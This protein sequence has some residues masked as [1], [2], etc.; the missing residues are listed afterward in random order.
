MSKFR[1]TCLAFIVSLTLLNYP[2]QAQRIIFSENFNGYPQINF[3]YPW[4]T[5]GS[6]NSVPW[7]SDVAY[8]IY[9]LG[10][11]DFENRTKMAGTASRGT[12]EHT[13]LVTPPINLGAVQH[14]WLSYDSYFLKAQNGGKTESATVEIRLNNDSTW[15]ILKD[16]PVSAGRHM[17]RSYVDLSSFIGTA[18]VWLGFRYS[19][20]LS[21]MAG[22]LVDNIKVFEPSEHDIALIHSY[23]EDTML[24]Y[25]A[26]PASIP[27]SGAVM[28][29][30]TMP[31]TSFTVAYQEG[32]GPVQTHTISG[33]N[34]APF[35]TLRFVH[36][37]PYSLATV[38]RHKL[39]MWVSTPQDTTSGNDTLAVLLH[40]AKF[41]PVKKIAI[42]EGTGTWNIY[43]PRGHVYLHKLDSGGHP[44]TRISV[45]SNDVMGQKAYAD[46]LYAMDQ[47]FV[48][49]FIFDRRGPVPYADFFERYETQKQ[50]FGFADIHFTGPS[51]A[52][53]LA[54]EAII[55]PAVNL[56]GSYRLALVV[57]EDGVKGTGDD[58]A[59]KNA[60]VNGHLGPMG[61]F[62]SKPDPV[63]ASDMV[64]DYVARS[65]NPDVLGQAGCLPMQMVAGTSYKCNLHATYAS[66]WNY[67]KL[68]AIVLLIR[69]SDSFRSFSKTVLFRSLGMES[70]TAGSGLMQIHPNPA[71]SSASIAFE[72]PSRLIT[73]MAVTDITGRVVLQS[74]GRW[75]DAGAQK[76]DI[77]VS[78]LPAG[79][80]FITLHAGDR[81]ETRKLSVVH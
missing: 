20:S 61:G 40:G 27:M 71:A 80:Y 39:K 57:T 70:F 44:P 19:D 30:G 50:Y 64:Y 41:I 75:T 11:L 78:R 31:I 60:Y 37:I 4:I 59:Q 55:I 38:D 62:E 14:A 65:I 6:A 16:A 13:L 22:W 74:P 56:S 32:L 15:T 25:F 52:G 81:Q 7:I 47:T 23:P 53:H 17:V 2:A 63:P 49:Y 77:D 12:S 42:E 68:N 18:S 76:M 67:N 28:N 5:S 66:S 33:V 54:L 21:R 1:S 9:G 73:S 35:D 72:L 29:T 69:D 10:Y 79:M 3:N 43:G 46:Y 36:S 24:S 48:P 8:L 45:H 34:I 26:S 58:Y 51:P